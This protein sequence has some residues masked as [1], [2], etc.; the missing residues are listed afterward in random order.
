MLCRQDLG[1]NNLQKRQIVLLL[2]ST[3]QAKSKPRPRPPKVVEAEARL[4]ALTSRRVVSVHVRSFLRTFKHFGGMCLQDSRTFIERNVSLA[5][6]SNSTFFHSVKITSV[7]MGMAGRRCSEGSK[8]SKAWWN[9]LL[10]FMM[11]ASAAVFHDVH[12][13]LLVSLLVPTDASQ[14][15]ADLDGFSSIS[16][17]NR[18]Q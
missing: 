10:V 12:V 13:F 8:G 7:F 17:P 5:A 18:P 6:Q 4:E 14:Q 1:V 2:C 3:V 16:N 15:F 11:V 9:L